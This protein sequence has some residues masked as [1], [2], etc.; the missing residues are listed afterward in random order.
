[1]S[2]IDRA[3]NIILTPAT[4]WPVIANEM[5]DTK[6]IFIGYAMVLAAIPAVITLFKGSMWGF[7]GGSVF[8]A[9]TY[10]LSLLTT[11]VLGLVVNALAP[12]FDGQK[13][14]TQAMKLAVYASTPAWVAGVLNIIPYLGT[15]VVF[16]AW[17]YGAYVL[18]LGIPSLMKAPKD[19][20]TGYAVV[21]FLVVMVIT[22]IFS[23][24]VIG[25]LM[26]MFFGGLS[27]AALSAMHH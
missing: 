9:I 14:K 8:A 17:L 20:A 27:I 12:N 24:V 3:K 19:K 10:V 1:M 15:F 16:L 18:Y 21:S 25:A 4:E 7:A 23:A 6:S 22:W 11:Y 26:S 2:L 5:T 13:D